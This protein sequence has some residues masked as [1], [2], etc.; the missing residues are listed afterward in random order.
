MLIFAR[1]DTIQAARLSF[2]EGFGFF[3]GIID[4]AASFLDWSARFIPPETSRR[5]RAEIPRVALLPDVLIDALCQGDF[6]RI[7]KWRRRQEGEYFL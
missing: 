6:L 3:P 7:I 5:L 4:R 2:P 1:R